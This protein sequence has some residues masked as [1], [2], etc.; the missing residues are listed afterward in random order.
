MGALVLT[1]DPRPDPEAA[2]RPVPPALMGTL[3]LTSD[4]PWL[5][6]TGT[7]PPTGLVVAPGV[8]VDVVPGVDVAPEPAVLPALEVVE[9]ASP[10][11]EPAALAGVCDPAPPPLMQFPSPWAEAGAVEKAEAANMPMVEAPRAAAMVTTR[12]RL[13]KVDIFISPVRSV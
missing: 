6:D 12:A 4:P 9:P 2:V 1:S 3:V 5:V 11:A 7:D 13:F 8:P 10:T